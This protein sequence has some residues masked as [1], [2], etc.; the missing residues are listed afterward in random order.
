MVA[1]SDSQKNATS[2]HCRYLLSSYQSSLPILLYHPCRSQMWK[3]VKTNILGMT[4]FPTIM[5]SKRLSEAIVSRIWRH[6]GLIRVSLT[7][8]RISVLLSRI[9]VYLMISYWTSRVLIKLTVAILSRIRRAWR[10]ILGCV[11]HCCHS[12]GMM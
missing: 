1:C 7:S 8:R 9:I 5:T 4:K 10:V 6:T 3:L 11:R 2:S 12:R